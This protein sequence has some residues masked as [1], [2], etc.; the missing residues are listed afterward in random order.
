MIV[1][2]GRSPLRPRRATRPR[3]HTRLIPGF[4]DLES[5]AVPTSLPAGFSETIVATGLTQPSAMAEAP[6][7]RIFVCEQGGTL[8]VIQDG[9][10][11][12]TPFVSLNVDSTGER[13]L[14]GVALDPDFSSHPF[15]Y[16]YYT[17]PGSPPHN[18]VSRFAG[19]GN[20]A[21]AG[22]EVALL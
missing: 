3:W 9:Q 16:V 10:L 6:D 14:L 2:R 17:V 20:V 5:R 15:V 11:L 21:R 7:G 8:R 1:G 19:D 4:D 12:A 13:G 18:R 22:S